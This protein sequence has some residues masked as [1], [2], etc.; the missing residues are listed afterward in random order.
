MLTEDDIDFN[1]MAKGVIA[2]AIEDF[3][4][5]N[6]KG[7]GNGGQCWHEVEEARDFLTATHGDWVESREIWCGLAD[8]DPEE[9]RKTMEK[10]RHS[11]QVFRRY[12]FLGDETQSSGD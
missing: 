8:I 9:L 2:Q 10:I 12:D 4:T 11:G 6:V 5:W 3:T 7:R 1:A